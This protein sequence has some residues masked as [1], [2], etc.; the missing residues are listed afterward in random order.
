MTSR[1]AAAR[2]ARRGLLAALL[3]ALAACAAPA[4]P[5]RP[6][7]QGVV[8]PS[9]ELVLA[10]GMTLAS[11]E[12][13]S[14]SPSFLVEPRPGLFLVELATVGSDGAF[15]FT[16]PDA[17]AVP[18]AALAPASTFLLNAATLPG[19]A[20]VPS[21]IDARVSTHAFGVPVAEDAIGLVTVPGLYAVTAE[22]GLLPTVAGTAPFDTSLTPNLAFGGR[23]VIAWL[24]ADRAVDVASQGAG[25][26]GGGF[27]LDVDLRLRA[28]WNQ[29]SWRFDD[30]FGGARVRNAN[31]ASVIVTPLTRDFPQHEGDDGT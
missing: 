18:A 13:L 22:S 9:G 11:A 28:G 31:V 16:L 2:A 20:L 14:P 26:S 1:P 19:C 23:T 7:A 25:C 10:V 6:S 15:A 4:D 27:D 21:V 30:A 12:A 17:D 29:V 24:F 3:L 5:G 8:A